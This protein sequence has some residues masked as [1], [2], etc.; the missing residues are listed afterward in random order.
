M[1][2]RTRAITSAIKSP[3]RSTPSTSLTSEQTNFPITGNAS[4]CL[5]FSSIS[6][7]FLRNVPH[8]H[9]GFVIL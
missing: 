2:M 9:D 6:F 3:V 5:L 8:E 4:I 1:T 7:F